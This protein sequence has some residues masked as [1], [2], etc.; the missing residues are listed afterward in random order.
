MKQRDFYT[1]VMGLNIALEGRGMVFMSADQMGD[2]IDLA[3]S[4]YELL[5]EAKTLLSAKR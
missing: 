2:P 1:R 4:D 3:Q 5:R